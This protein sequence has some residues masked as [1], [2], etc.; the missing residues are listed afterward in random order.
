MSLAL[1]HVPTPATA[2]TLPA[3]PSA[4][5]PPRRAESPGG[6][7]LDQAPPA[8]ARSP[9][10]VRDWFDIAAEAAIPDYD[11]SIGTARSAAQAYARRAK[12][13]TRA[14]LIAPGCAP[15]AIGVTSTP[16]P[17]LRHPVSSFFRLGVIL[18]V[19]RRFG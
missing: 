12:A 15:G 17:Y 6:V 13:A 4:I 1:T 7:P 10:V 2:D 9:V 5:G 14:A 11:G 18:F 3:L 8:R 16:S 19:W